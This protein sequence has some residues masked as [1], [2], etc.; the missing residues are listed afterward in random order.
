MYLYSLKTTPV[1]GI[2]HKHELTT[3]VLEGIHDIL[4][5]TQLLLVLSIWRSILYTS[6]MTQVVNA[7]FYIHLYKS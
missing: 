4:M 3:Y 1:L 5:E 7:L 6:E 2:L